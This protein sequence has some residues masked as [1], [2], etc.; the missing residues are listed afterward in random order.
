MS[1]PVKQKIIA[2]FYGRLSPKDEAGLLGWVKE[3][4]TNRNYFFQL[5]ESLDPEKMEHPLLRS[6]YAELQNKLMIDQQFRSASTGKFRKLQLSF[7]RI[8][9]MLLLAL[10]LGFA[11]A[12]LITGIPLEKSQVVWFE[13]HVPRGEKS[14]LLLPDGSKVWLNS[15]SILSYP[16]NFMDGDRDVKLKGEAYFEVSKVNGSLFTVE[17]RDYNVRVLGTKFNVTAY[18]DFNRTETT[19]IEGRIEV[20]KGKQTIDVDP[21][22]TLTYQDNQF[23]TKMSNAPKSARWKDDIFDFDRITFH[24]LVIRLERWYDV[25]IEIKSPDLNSIVYSGVFKNEETIDQVLNTLELTMP[26]HYTRDGF[27]KFKVELN[28]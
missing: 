28:R 22:E 17:T 26:I 20:R 24:E 11:I 2:Y 18:A 9:A 8:A 5:K 3:S 14:Q 10:T 21:G 4:E 6:S 25:D 12:W 15:E 1:D 23:F 16:S 27:R 7:T 13:T 19:L